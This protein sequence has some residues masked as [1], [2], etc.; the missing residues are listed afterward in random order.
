[1]LKAIKKSSNK[2]NTLNLSLISLLAGLIS[3]QFSYF[4]PA[5]QFLVTSSVMIITFSPFLYL[6][7]NRRRFNLLLT[8]STLFLIFL[9]GLN[10][11][12]SIL[13]IFTGLSIFRI[14]ACRKKLKKYFEAFQAH[15]ADFAATFAAL[16][17]YQEAN[18]FLQRL[19]SYIGKLPALLTVK[20]GLILLILYFVKH[21][22]EGEDEVMMLNIVTVLGLSMAARN[23][24]LLI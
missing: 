10:N 20:I 14:P 12:K 13:V 18:P 4:D 11:F 9:I 21:E 16:P 3:I 23:F 15:L 17:A 1:M 7:F 6:N 19:I 24:L 8:S 5:L 22:F 2:L